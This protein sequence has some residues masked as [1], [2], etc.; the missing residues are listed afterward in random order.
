MRRSLWLSLLVSAGIL[1][2]GALVA[3]ENVGAG[4]EGTA[5][6]EAR[7]IDEKQELQDAT[8]TMREIIGIPEEGI[9]QALLSESAAVVVVPDVIKA[10]FVV[11]GRHGDGVMVVRTEDGSWSNPVFVELTGASVGWQVGVEATDIVLVFKNRDAAWKVLN[12]EFTLGADG[13]VAAGP[14][15]RQ[16]SAGTGLKLD[17]EVYSYSRSRGLFAGV[18]ID[19]SKLSVNRD[20]NARFYGEAY[21]DANVLIAAKDLKAPSEAGAFVAEL[22]KHTTK[23]GS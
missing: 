23:P 20:A 16:A 15:G 3:I 22:S 21:A 17:H 18:S 14:V 9:P 4:D 13:S 2:A 12:G 19:G 11:G 10:G 1:L 8:D 6:K 7:S 5:N